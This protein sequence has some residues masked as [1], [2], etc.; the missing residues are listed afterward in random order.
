MFTFL[1]SSV[2]VLA[3]SIRARSSGGT[4]AEEDNTTKFQLF[5]DASSP[6]KSEGFSST[7]MSTIEADGVVVAGGVVAAPAAVSSVA[8]LYFAA[9]SA[10]PA[11]YDRSC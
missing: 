10:V 4:A 9:C 8:I 6:T 3:F 7:R 11:C 2:V 5:H 1:M